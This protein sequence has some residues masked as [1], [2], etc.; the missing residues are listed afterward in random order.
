MPIRAYQCSCGVVT[1][2]LFW[3]EYP[4][5]IPCPVCGGKAVHRFMDTHY[6]KLGD[7]Q[8]KRYKVDFRE[9]WDPGAGR[10]FSRKA[11]REAY[12]RETDCTYRKDMS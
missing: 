10:Y 9:G 8:P 6:A 5:S 4:R 7:R 11:D 12:C 3:K 1:D 2:E